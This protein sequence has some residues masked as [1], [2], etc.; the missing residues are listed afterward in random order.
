MTHL[1]GNWSVGGS[2]TLCGLAL[3]PD[4][5]AVGCGG[6]DSRLREV[7]ICFSK[8]GQPQPCGANEAQRKL[9]RS[10][11]MPVPPVR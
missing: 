3:K 5:L 9:C 4:M 7:R 2:R 10:A 8:G 11:R 1:I 6:K